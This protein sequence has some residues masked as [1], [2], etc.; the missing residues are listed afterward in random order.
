MPAVPVGAA[1][2]LVELAFTLIVWFAPPLILYVI[3]TAKACGFVKVT[4][5]DEPFLQTAVVPL[6]AAVGV[7]LTVT[8]AVCPVIVV[9]QAGPDWYDAPVKL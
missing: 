3:V 8:V 1:T 5:G 7:G 6:I 4:F 9:L 2:V